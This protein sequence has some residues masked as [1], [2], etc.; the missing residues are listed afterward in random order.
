MVSCQP[1]ESYGFDI[2]AKSQNGLRQE[3]KD[4]AEITVCTTAALKATAKSDSSS[5]LGVGLESQKVSHKREIKII[6]EKQ[7][8]DSITSSQIVS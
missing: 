5:G 8:K 4:S 6:P 7:L 1:P 3:E 2:V